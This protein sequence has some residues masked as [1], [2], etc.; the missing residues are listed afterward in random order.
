M[1]KFKNIPIRKTPPEYIKNENIQVE[2]TSSPFQGRHEDCIGQHAVTLQ[3][4]GEYGAY[5]AIH[6]KLTEFQKLTVGAHEAL[7]AGDILMSERKVTKL[8]HIIAQ[9][10]W[11]A[12]FRKME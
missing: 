8:S 9:T 5:I 12:G 3:D 11:Q 4:N 10:L 6:P 2:Y 1:L 7:H